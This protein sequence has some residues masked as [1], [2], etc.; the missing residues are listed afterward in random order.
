MAVISSIVLITCCFFAA[1]LPYRQPQKLPDQARPLASLSAL[2]CLFI[3]LS[4]VISL[5]V[6]NSGNVSQAVVIIFDNL[7]SYLALPLLSSLIVSA[8]SKRYLTK[9][10][11]GRVSLVMLATFEVCR[12]AEIGD[13]YS[14]MIAISSSLV[15][16][17]CLLIW[18]K[19]NAKLLFANI[20]TLISY[21]LA[22]VVLSKMLA[23]QYQNIVLYQ[24]FLGLAL[25]GITYNLSIA[26]A[27]IKHTTSE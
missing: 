26:I 10:T 9:A 27:K 6:S 14:N 13:I 7:A 8:C 25:V 20:V 1:I 17:A 16:A 24:C 21:S 11:W 2:S 19:G 4:A 12:R 3:A 22:T 18:Q 5:F 15:I 23:T